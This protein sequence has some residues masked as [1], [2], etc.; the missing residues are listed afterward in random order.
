MTR[1]QM[2]MKVLGALSK[3]DGIHA[4]TSGDLSHEMTRIPHSTTPLGR[5]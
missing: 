3:G 1:D 4:F 5:F 2:K